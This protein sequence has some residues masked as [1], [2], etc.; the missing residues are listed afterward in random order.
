MAAVYETSRA[1]QARRFGEVVVYVREG[2]PLRV[3]AAPRPRNK[4]DW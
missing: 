1:Q 4:T 2:F 3:A